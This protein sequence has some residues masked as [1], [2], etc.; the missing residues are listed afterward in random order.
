MRFTEPAFVSLTYA[1]AII[2]HKLCVLFIVDSSLGWLMISYGK[3]KRKMEVGVQ[4]RNRTIINGK[5]LL[6]KALLNRLIGLE[7]GVP[8]RKRMIIK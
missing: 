5:E 1:F 8:K 6:N 3:E 4:K 2:V 7:V